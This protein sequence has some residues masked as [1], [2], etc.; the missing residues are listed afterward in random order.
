MKFKVGDHV[1]FIGDSK[2]FSDYPD[3]VGEKLTIEYVFS[4]DT[5]FHSFNYMVV[6]GSRV[7]EKDLVYWDEGVRLFD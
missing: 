7:W 3:L 4:D 1:R 6:G 2:R 5:P